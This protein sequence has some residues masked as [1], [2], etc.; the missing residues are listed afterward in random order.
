M[1]FSKSIGGSTASSPLNAT[2]VALGQNSNWGPTTGVNLGARPDTLVSKVPT[3]EPAK[4]GGTPNVNAGK[5][6]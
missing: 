6:K 3:P 1:S 2:G 4:S 5:P